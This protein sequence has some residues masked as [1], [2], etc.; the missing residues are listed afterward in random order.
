LKKSWAER[1]AVQGHYQRFE[2][3]LSILPGCGDV[4]ANLAKGLRAFLGAEAT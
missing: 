4:A 1:I 2:H 3:A